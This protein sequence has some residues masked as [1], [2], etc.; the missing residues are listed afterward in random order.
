MSARASLGS[1]GLL[2][3]IVAC[4]RADVPTPG[5]R[6]VRWEGVLEVPDPPAGVQ[7]VLY[8]AG[9]GSGTAVLTPGQP[10]GSCRMSPR[11][12]AVQGPLPA[13]DDHEAEERFFKRPDLPR[14]VPLEMPDRIPESD[15]RQRIRVEYRVEG[16]E[17]S[18]IRLSWV[19]RGYGADEALVFEQRGAAASEPTLEPPTVQKHTGWCALGPGAP[20]APLVGLSLTAL[21][22][23][24]AVVLR[25]RAA[26]G[27]APPPGAGP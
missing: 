18:V 21:L 17:G 16:I 11:I 3:A 1:L 23:L 4:T 2:V 5:Y 27:E 22:L 26:L 7:F 14:S 10:F 19:E 8:P 12:Y 25:R 15:R 13:P 6:S 9:L 24:L 20:D